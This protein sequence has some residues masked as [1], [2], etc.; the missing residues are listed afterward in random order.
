[1]K[2]KSEN[3]TVNYDA[4]QV[5]ESVAVSFTKVTSAAGVAIYGK[6][7]KDGADAG[8]VSYEGKG[9]YFIT[10]LKP[11]SMF[12]QEDIVSIYALVPSCIEEILND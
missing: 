3:A 9:D 6:I 11:K 8:S 1:M 12:T 10:S 7:T 5:N 2:K 4:V